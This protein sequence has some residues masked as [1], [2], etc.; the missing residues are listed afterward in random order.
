L[1]RTVRS[2]YLILELIFCGGLYDVLLSYLALGGLVHHT[3]KDST[4]R[5]C[6]FPLRLW[7]ESDWQQHKHDHNTWQV[8]SEKKLRELS[9]TQKQQR[10]IGD[11]CPQQLKIPKDKRFRIKD[12]TSG[13]MR[14]MTLLEV[15]HAK[16]YQKTAESWKQGEKDIFRGKI[17]RAYV[18]L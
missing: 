16:K 11:W 2:R 15:Q 4:F 12:K 18:L 1:A 7:K 10:I 17:G 14:N 9:W 8:L 5:Y 6:R 13:K 3:V